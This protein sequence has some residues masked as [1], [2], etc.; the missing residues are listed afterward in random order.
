MNK[1][2]YILS[3]GRIKRKDNTIYM[4]KGQQKRPIPIKGVE[5]LYF[6][7]EVDINSKILNFLAQNRILVHF[8]NYYGYYTGSFYPRE[9]LK[10]GITVVKQVDHYKDSSKRLIIA[11][12]VLDGAFHNMLVNM[13]YYEK[14]G[15]E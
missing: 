15:K 7:G 5:S 4:D 10:S 13:K 1:E 6:F 2:Y 14:R 12:E 9:Y 11:K 3:S 8:F